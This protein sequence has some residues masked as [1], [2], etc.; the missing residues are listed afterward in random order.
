MR[1][2]HRGRAHREGS[3]SFCLRVQFCPCGLAGQYLADHE[4]AVRAFQGIATKA[5]DNVDRNVA[6]VEKDGVVQLGSQLKLGC[7][8][9]EFRVKGASLFR[10][11]TGHSSAIRLAQ[12]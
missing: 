3:R 11:H 8:G 6:I 5:A 2:T 9:I 12:I 10:C 4:T 1:P 7:P